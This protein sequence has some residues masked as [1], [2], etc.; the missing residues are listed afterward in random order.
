MRVH[1][2]QTRNEKLPRPVNSYGSRWH[3]DAR[4]ETRDPASRDHHRHAS[5][6]AT[7]GNIDNGCIGDR[8][9]AGSMAGLAGGKVAADDDKKECRENSHAHL[10]VGRRPRH[11]G[12]GR[13]RQ[14]K[15]T[16]S[17]QRNFAEFFFFLP[18]VFSEFQF[19]LNCKGIK[20]F[21]SPADVLCFSQTAT[22]PESELVRVLHSSADSCLARDQQTHPRRSC[23]RGSHDTLAGGMTDP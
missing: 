3:A 12:N 2:P 17:E 13:T 14:E 18:F 15:K 23:E 16:S 21:R 7:A 10:E 6:L 9:R 5:L 19:F 4:T 20:N 8:D 22:V 11:P 1:I